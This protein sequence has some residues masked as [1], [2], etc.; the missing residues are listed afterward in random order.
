MDKNERNWGMFLHFSVFASYV[1]P[2]AGLV[3][4]IVIWQLK[5]EEYPS[6]DAH[7]KNV[8]NFL[9]SMFIYSIVAV[10][11]SFLL[12][13]IPI[14]VA[15]TIAGIVLPIIAG[16]KANQGEIWKYPYTLTVFS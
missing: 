1:I 9:I 11:L 2:I 8:M 13:G 16:I 4:P 15:L 14:L 5:K 10:L 7:G 12:I 3:V 6:I